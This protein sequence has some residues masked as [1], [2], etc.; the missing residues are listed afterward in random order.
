MRNLLTGVSFS[1]LGGQ[2]SSDQL[3]SRISQLPEEQIA[4]IK[5]LRAAG[6]SSRA[7]GRILNIHNSTVLKYW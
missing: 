2:L 4:T 5:E 7:I 3:G 6:N 1:H